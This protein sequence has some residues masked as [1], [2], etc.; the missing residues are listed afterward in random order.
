[1]NYYVLRENDT[2][3]RLS[4]KIY[5]DWTLWKLLYFFN[6]QVLKNH[7]QNMFPSGTL[8]QVPEVNLH[9]ENHIV[10]VG[11]TYES[12]SLSFYGIEQYSEFI[13]YSNNGL[14]LKYNAGEEIVIPSLI[15]KKRGRDFV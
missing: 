14:L 12:L 10:S 3:Q 13:K 1:M 9:D 2:L 15:Q 11:D 5:T 6:Y 7:P 8:I 4:A